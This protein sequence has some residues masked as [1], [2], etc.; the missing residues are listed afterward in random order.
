MEEKILELIKKYKKIIIARHIGGDPDALG[1]TFALKEIILENFPDKEVYVAGASISKFKFFGSH[2]KITD[3]MCDDALLIAL[4]IPDIKRLDGVDYYK[5]K[6]VVKIDHHPEIDKFSDVEIIDI[7]ASSASEL[8]AKWCYNCKLRMPRHAAENLFMGIVADTN[9]F[10]FGANKPET[11]RIVL[12]LVEKSHIK[13][14]ELYEL[15]YKRSMSEVRLEGFVS[16][17][18]KITK[19]GLGYVKITDKDLKDYGV[20]SASI[21][22]IMNDYNFIHG[23]ICWVV[24]TEDLKNN[25]IRTSARSRGVKINKLF[26]QYNGG[27]HVY[28]CGAKLNSFSEADEII[29]KLDKLCKEYKEGEFK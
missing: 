12:N 16:L 2:D 28:A 5:F 6:E 26:E 10:L 8:I 21:G 15:L 22:S 25:V 20:D 27:G 17:N 14:N 19:N 24:F 7:D 9:R 1:A 11:Y 13:P 29:D 23:L 18:M 3:E 4:D